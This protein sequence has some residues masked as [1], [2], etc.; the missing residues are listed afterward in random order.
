MSTVCYMPTASYQTSSSSWDW[1]D[2]SE[3]EKGIARRNLSVYLIEWNFSSL[4]F[5]YSCF[6]RKLYKKLSGFK[7]WNIIFYCFSFGRHSK[8]NFLC[9]LARVNDDESSGDDALKTLFH[10]LKNVLNFEKRL[11]NVFVDCFFYFFFFFVHVNA[12]EN[13]LYPPCV[14]FNLCKDCVF[15]GIAIES[16]NF[17]RT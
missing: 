1:Q 8:R 14:H 5:S 13:C 7:R 10:F 3:N 12:I 15:G 11:K 9:T 4:H 6:A 2:S 16:R 17:S